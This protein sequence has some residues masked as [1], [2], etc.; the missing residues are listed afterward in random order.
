LM[1]QDGLWI[2]SNAEAHVSKCPSWVSHWLI[3][4]LRP[5]GPYRSYVYSS[6]LISYI[7]FYLIQLP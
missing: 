7:C 3:I 2:P 5:L 1:N 6:S 4:I